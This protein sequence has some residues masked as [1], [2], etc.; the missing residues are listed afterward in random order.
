[1]SNIHIRELEE[2]L[3]A[4]DEYAIIDIRTSQEYNTGHIPG[5]HHIPREHFQKLKDFSD[6]KAVYIH[7]RSGNR[8]KLA[9]D[10][11]KTHLPGSNLHLIVDSG[12]MHWEQEGKP[13]NKKAS[14]SFFSK[15]T[16]PLD[17]GIRVALGVIGIGSTFFVE[18][19]YQFLGLIGIIPLVTGTTGICPLY[20]FF[21]I[22]TCKNKN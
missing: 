16:G 5:S 3:D 6:H 9:A 12:F 18:G 22:N 2:Y 17:R 8:V 15:N 1:M 14:S 11:I 20:S 4:P 10:E 13:V 19:P 21:G 7:C